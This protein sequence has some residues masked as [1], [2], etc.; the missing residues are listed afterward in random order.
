VAFV[1][2]IKSSLQRSSY[3]SM[4]AEQRMY[5]KTKR[6]ANRQDRWKNNDFD[7]VAEFRTTFSALYKIVQIC[8]C[9]DVVASLSAI[10]YEGRQRLNSPA[11]STSSHL[12]FSYWNFYR[13]FFFFCIIYTGADVKENLAKIHE[14]VTLR[15]L[16]SACAISSAFVL[17]CNLESEID[18]RLYV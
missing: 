8:K 16:R 14:Y 9:V 4:I 7:R 12:E 15:Q 10:G 17:V 6:N 3:T 5:Q 18:H 2:S 1:A 13:V 11:L